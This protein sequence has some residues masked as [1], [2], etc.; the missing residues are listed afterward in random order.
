MSQFRTALFLVTV[1]LVS[2]DT[3]R[4]SFDSEFQ[5]SGV[6]DL[7][8]GLHARNDNLVWVSGTNGL[9]LVTRDGGR[10][11]DEFRYM[12][13]DSLQFRDIHGFSPR[14]AVVL[15]AGDGLMSKILTFTQDSG[16]VVK[17]EMDHPVGFLN[18]LDFWDNQIGIAFGDAIDE[19]PFILKTIDGGNSWKRIS[20]SKLPDA[21]EGE[22]GF[23][24]SGT[25]IELGQNGKVWIGTGAGGNARILYS[26][27][28]GENWLNISTPMVKGEMAGIMSV[29]FIGVKGFISG[30]DLNQAQ[31]ITNNLYRTINGGLFWEPAAAPRTRGPIYGSAY[32]VFEKRDV[33]LITGPNGADISYDF[34][35]RWANISRANF[36]S[37][38]LLP[39]GKGWLVGRNGNIMKVQI[40][41]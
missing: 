41:L 19:K 34:G 24:S 20:K 39:T 35:N 6:E 40:S 2:C 32:T 22:G 10:N 1:V 27:D 23:A 9:V 18:S 28:Y 7:L 14:R 33:L 3:T 12:T 21:G 16:F 29:R 13:S 38:D 5:E 17:Y 4:L 11:W 25:N 15:S 36:W 26:A 8:I 31:G 37:A 30:G